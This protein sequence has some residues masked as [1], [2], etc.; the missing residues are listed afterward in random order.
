FLIDVR[1]IEKAISPRTRLIVLTNMHNPT[2]TLADNGT[3]NGIGEIARDARARVLVDEVYLEAMF[4]HAPRSSFHLGNQ[5]VATGSL[6]KAYGLSG[7][8]AGWVLAEAP[9]AE[10]MWRLNDIFGVIPAHPAERL[11]VV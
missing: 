2:S 11:S 6:T 3:L 7:L 1:E 10:K 5:F 9:L 4:D 8:R